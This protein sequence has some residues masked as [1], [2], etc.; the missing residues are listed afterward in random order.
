MSQIPVQ[1]AEK[2]FRD[3]RSG[4]LSCADQDTYNKYMAARKSEEVKKQKFEALQNDVSLLKSDMSEIKS[5]L[6][7]LANN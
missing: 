3:S 1:D 6:Q 5:L 4:S 2:W 7:K